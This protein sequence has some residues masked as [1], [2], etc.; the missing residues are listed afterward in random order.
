M[1]YHQRKCLPSARIYND[2]LSPSAYNRGQFEEWS[3]EDDG[4]DVID[5]S[6]FNQASV[7]SEEDW[8][9]CDER[10]G[11]SS[12]TIIKQPAIHIVKGTKYVPIVSICFNI[13]VVVILNLAVTMIFI[14]LLARQA[15]VSDS[16]FVVWVSSLL[17]SEQ[18]RQIVIS[19]KQGPCGVVLLALFVNTICKH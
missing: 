1:N 3:I 19:I 16:Y 5:Y 6:Q 9:D 18:T 14:D 12:I 4:Y 7:C 15:V 17:K 10:S 13:G 11:G 2:D 8:M